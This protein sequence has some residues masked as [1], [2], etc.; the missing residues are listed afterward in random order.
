M[1]AAT[2]SWRRRRSRCGASTITSR[3]SRRRRSCSIRRGAREIIAS[4][5]ARPSPSRRARTGRGDGA[6]RRG[7]RA[8]RMAGGAD[9]RVRRGVPVDLRRGDPRHHPQ[10][11]EMLRA[12]RSEDGEA[13]QPFHP[14]RQHRGDATAARRSSPAT[15]ASSAR[16]CPTRGSSARRTCKTPLEERLPKLEQIVFHDKL[17]TQAERIERI[18]ALAGADR[19]ARRRRL[20][21]AERAARLCQGR[22]ARPRWSASSP[23][24]RA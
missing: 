16:G 18:D 22:S 23:S 9:G 19:A 13:R 2:A 20:A 6:A 15:S 4:R 5:R 24:C 3:S 1:T 10:Q 14:D 11:P 17:G 8:G 7:R 12:A 21:K